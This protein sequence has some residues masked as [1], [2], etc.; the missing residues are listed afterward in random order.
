MKLRPTTINLFDTDVREF[1]RRAK[2]MLMPWQVW[3]RLELH[4]L[5]ITP[6]PEP[7]APEDSKKVR[8][9]L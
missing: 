5:A 4:R 8:T 7:P 9:I 6:E 2:K 3:L 1:Q